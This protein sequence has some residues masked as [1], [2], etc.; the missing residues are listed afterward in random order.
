MLVRSLCVSRGGVCPHFVSVLAVQSTTDIFCVLSLCVYV[1]ACASS[2]GALVRL[3]LALE[4]MHMRAC[5]LI[6][7]VLARTSL[8]PQTARRGGATLYHRRPDPEYYEC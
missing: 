6:R 4:H 8:S 2:F 5:L 1:C 7:C 3:M